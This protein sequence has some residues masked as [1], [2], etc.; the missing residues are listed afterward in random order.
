M[1]LFNIKQGRNI[2][3]EGTPLAD[4]TRANSSVSFAF[5]P[6]DF[7]GLKFKLEVAVGDK[8]KV[9]DPL[10]S[11]RENPGMKF[12]SPAGGLVKEIKRGD[13]RKLLEIVVAQQEDEEYKQFDTYTA[14]DLEKIERNVLINHLLESGLW[15]YIIQR[16]F[17]KVADPTKKPKSIF[18]RAMDTEPNCA[19]K[20]ILVEGKD[21]ELQ[22][23]INAMKRLTEGKVYFCF[24]GNSKKVASAVST[25]AGAEIHQFKGAH[26]SGNVGTHIHYL[27]PINKGDQVWH[28][29]VEQLAYI[30]EFL[31]KGKIPVERIIALA[32]S[33]VKNPKYY[34]TRLGAS[35]ESLTQNNLKEGEIR[36]L[37]GGV[38]WRTYC[39]A[40]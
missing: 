7:S 20:Q 1:T 34:K 36:I 39:C 16:P 26:P 23:G 21:Q 18:I 5:L 10:V 30:G 19:D 24:D 17:S 40:Q 31:L 27:D 28:I 25:L 29:D 14:G 9:G 37:N 32:G 22:A 13:K 2:P 15:P 33:S 11:S 6:T 35:I 8:V 12:I 38:F 3:I 4:V